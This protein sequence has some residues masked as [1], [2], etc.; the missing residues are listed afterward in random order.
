[1]SVSNTFKNKMIISILLSTISIPALSLP[2]ANHINSKYFSV[3]LVSLKENKNNPSTEFDANI[4]FKVGKDIPKGWTLGFYS[5]ETFKQGDGKNKD[6]KINLIGPD[7][8][9]I[10]VMVD[11]PFHLKDLRKKSVFSAGTA[12]VLEEKKSSALKKG[13]YI[14]QAQGVDGR[15]SS[16]SLAPQSFFLS[17]NDGAVHLHISNPSRSEFNLISPVTPVDKLIS[18][19]KSN[20][21]KNSIP[22]SKSDDNVKYHLVPSVA[23]ISSEKGYIDLNKYSGIGAI[24]LDKSMISKSNNGLSESFINNYIRSDKVLSMLYSGG[25]SKIPVIISANSSSKN[26]IEGYKLLI[27]AGLHPCIEIKANGYAGVFYAI[28]TLKQIFYYA[29]NNENHLP[30]VSIVDEPRFMYRGVLLDVARHYFAIKDIERLID[31]MAA[32]KLNVLHVHFS[33]DEAFRLSLNALSSKK[34]STGVRSFPANYFSAVPAYFSQGNL[35]ITNYRL[36]NISKGE[37]VNKHYPTADEPY[38]SNVNSLSGGEDAPGMYSKQSIKN[39]IKYANDRNVFIEPEIDIP[40]H[41]Y[42]LQHAMDFDRDKSEKDSYIS[43]QGFTDDTLPICTYETSEGSNFTSKINS[44]IKEIGSEFSQQNTSLNKESNILDNQLSV[45]GDEVSASAWKH[46][47][48]C[49]KFKW[50][51]DARAKAQYLFSKI[52]ANNKVRISGWQQVVSDSNNDIPKGEHLSN[53]QAGYLFAWEPSSSG[54]I[55]AAKNLINNGYHTVLAFAD[56]SYFD[57]AYS[58]S[59]D[60]PGFNWAN[61]FSDTE[62]GLNL[63]ADAAKV[64]SGSNAK[65]LDGLE[66]ALWSENMMNYRHLSYMALPK[67]SGLAEAAWSP[68]GTTT[69]VKKQNP[70]NK[71]YYVD[72]QSLAKRLGCGAASNSSCSNILHET[73]VSSHLDYLYKFVMLEDSGQDT[74]K[75]FSSTGTYRGYPNGIAKEIP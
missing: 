22:V 67:I 13:D 5:A 45:G 36:N 74:G 70:E 55:S 66:G 43:V 39:L 60:E 57:L 47:P 40:G 65:Y 69:N 19:H 31:V 49:V 44:I 23:H 11:K 41:A 50:P 61:K 8:K 15:P 37:E 20:I 73:G 10:G 42:A 53:A 59:P 38:P 32:E 24:K 75:Y 6:L 48:E 14:L 34:A 33:D 1:M 56:D 54:G 27:S 63:A 64:I 62:S 52:A 16:Y 2:S 3:N 7:N 25:S 46:D 29:H 21:W 35:D 58:P 12:V 18:D 68:F 4:H 30:I 26:S 9:T 17:Y 28:Q 51:D 71:K 72:W